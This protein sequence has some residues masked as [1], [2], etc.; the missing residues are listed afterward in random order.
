MR[1]RATSWSSLVI[2]A[3]VVSSG[4]LYAAKGGRPKKTP[5][6]VTYLDSLGDKIQSDGMDGMSP[7]VNGEDGV[8]AT[9]SRG[10]VL[11][12]HDGPRTLFLDFI[13]LIVEREFNFSLIPEST[14]YPVFFMFIAP[15]DCTGPDGIL[16]TV[17]DL[18]VCPDLDEGFRAITSDGLARLVLNL[19]D[20]SSSDGSEYRLRM[21]PNSFSE[22]EVNLGTDHLVV[23]CVNLVNGSCTQWSVAVNAPDDVAHLYRF[24][25]RQRKGVKPK[26]EEVGDFHMPHGLTITINP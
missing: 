18:D 4:A 26:R 13:D 2:L 20:L 5:V 25:P 19:P 17:D 10:V 22:Q 7:Y 3:L 12:T 21:G 16:G 11:R 24:T 8:D 6:T 14:D 1:A 15:V 9:L 23:S